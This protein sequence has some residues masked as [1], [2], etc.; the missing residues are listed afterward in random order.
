MKYHEG[1]APKGS[2]ERSKDSWAGRNQEAKGTITEA[3]GKVGAE[4]E[5][6]REKEGERQVKGERGIPKSRQ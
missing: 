5:G 1:L 4:R 3:G 6:E 2:S